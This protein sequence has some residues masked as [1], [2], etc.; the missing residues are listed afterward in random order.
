MIE[1]TMQESAPEAVE[2]SSEQDNSALEA[3]KQAQI[4]K[5]KETN[6]R[7][8]RKAAENAQR[9]RDDLRQQLS[10]YEQQSRPAQP[11]DEDVNIN[12]DDL[13]EGKHLVK[14]MDKIKRL[15]EQ[16]RAFQQ[17]TFAS[18]AETRLRSQYNDFDKVVTLENIEKLSDAFPE[19]AKSINSSNDLYDK[20]V[21][22]YT[23]IK[24]FG[25]YEENPHQAEKQKAIDNSNKPRPLA[26]VS[27]Q[28]GDSPL[29]R[30]NAFANGLTKDL[31]DQLRKEMEDARK[32]Y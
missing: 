18:T 19:L 5:D 3:A 29:S 23:L 12:P 21:S 24:R 16:Q 8:L 20:A 2:S 4:E 25:I 10:R 30:A 11:K 28:Q 26:S 32:S 9:E 6:I 13:V 14:A 15:E 27:P 7:A 22:A 1:D 17:Q 31:K